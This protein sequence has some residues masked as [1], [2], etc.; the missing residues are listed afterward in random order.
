MTSHKYK[1]SGKGT[2]HFLRVNSV[3][4]IMTNIWRHS[5]LMHAFVIAKYYL[6]NIII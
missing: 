6:E 1:G 2:V 3:F 4:V 5:S